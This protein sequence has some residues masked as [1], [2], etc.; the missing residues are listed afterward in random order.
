MRGALLHFPD[1]DRCENT[2]TEQKFVFCQGKK[3]D[4]DVREEEEK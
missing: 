2:E 3:K 4:E 1:L